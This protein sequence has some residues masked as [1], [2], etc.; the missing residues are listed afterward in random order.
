VQWIKTGDDMIGEPVFED[1]GS[2]LSLMQRFE[3][4]RAGQERVP[5]LELAMIIEKHH[6]RVLPAVVSDYLTQHFRGK[7][8]VAK[9][10]KLQ[11]DADKDFRFGP[12]AERYRRVLPRFEYLAKRQKRPALKR[13]IPKGGPT[14]QERALKPSERA[15]QYVIKT[16]KDELGLQTISNPRSLANEISKRQRAIEKR[17]FS[18]QERN[19]HPTDEPEIIS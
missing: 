2:L 19:G 9:G 18:D 11:S 1:Q 8:K 3:A 16:M 12:A 13:R 15:L 4:R 5:D 17:E 7:I 10:P 14:L 6:G